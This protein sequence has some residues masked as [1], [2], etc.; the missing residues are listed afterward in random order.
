MFGSF[1]NLEST[2]IMFRNGFYVFAA[3]GTMLI[4]LVF[5]ANKDIAQVIQSMGTIPGFNER[6]A[7]MM[8]GG[9]S[10]AMGF[11][12][13]RVIIIYVSCTHLCKLYTQYT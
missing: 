11:Y 8:I 2:Q 9:I 6:V 12:V 4:A 10:V 7:K 3:C 5:V 1:L 13:S